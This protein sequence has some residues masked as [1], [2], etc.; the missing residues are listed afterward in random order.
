MPSSLCIFKSKDFLAGV[1]RMPPTKCTCPPPKIPKILC[2]PPEIPIESRKF[3]AGAVVFFPVLFLFS[4][5]N[6]KKTN[7]DVSSNK[8]RFCTDP[9]LNQF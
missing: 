7:F 6:E 9:R 3:L 5:H 4:R 2:P 1:L 8:Y